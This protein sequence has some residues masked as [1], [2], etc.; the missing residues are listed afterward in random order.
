[1]SVGSRRGSSVDSV[2]LSDGHLAGWDRTIS[3][4]V[5]DRREGCGNPL[6]MVEAETVA[7]EVVAENSVQNGQVRS[8]VCAGVMPT[9]TGPSSP[10]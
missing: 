1:V 8:P 9:V 4:V 7:S 3:T 2:G 10:A 6:S 5:V